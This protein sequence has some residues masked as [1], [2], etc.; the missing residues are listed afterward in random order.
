MHIPDG[1]LNNGTAS[2]L[3]VAAA[4]AV[5]FAFNKVREAFFVK[6][7]VAVLKTPEGIEMSGSA[8]TRLT[9]Y[10]KSK[11]FKM[12]TLGVFIF[13]A[14]LLDFANIQGFP[15]HFLG[16]TLA[17][18]ILGPLEGF[19]VITVVLIVQCLALGDGGLMALGANIF[20]M[21]IIGTIGAG[22]L[23]HFFIKHI[24][25]NQMVAGGVAFLSVLLTAVF[26]GGEL[27][28][29]NYQSLSFGQIMSINLLVGTIEGILTILF[30]KLF[31]YK[32]NN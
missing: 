17:A 4:G 13:G 26:Y 21:G 27:A 11:I 30:L 18:I 12:L 5:V 14:Q 1:F 22:Y 25:K 28:M 9:Q 7:K 6:E 8:V 20:N 19:L 16:G 10:G 3:I 2:S 23:Y 24:K 29:V 31:R 32:E 15:I